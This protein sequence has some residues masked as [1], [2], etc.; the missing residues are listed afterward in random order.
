[1]AIAYGA[2]K[3][4]LAGFRFSEP[5]VT[6]GVGLV[7]GLVAY[8]FGSGMGIFG[9]TSDGASFLFLLTAL[10]FLR[11]L[12]V[13]PSRA[14]AYVVIGGLVV[15]SSS[16]MYASLSNPYRAVSVWE[17]T[18]RVSFSKGGELFLDAMTAQRIED[19][20]DALRQSGISNEDTVISL[21][22]RWNST[23][24]YLNGVKPFPTLMPTLFGYHGEIGKLEQNL[25]YSLNQGLS[26]DKPVYF[27]T[28][29]PGMIG[30]DE[31]HR[32]LRA[33]EVTEKMIFR[34][35]ERFSEILWTDDQLIVWKTSKVSAE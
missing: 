35:E 32:V 22:W 14:A 19:Y 10:I 16:S 26:S 3:L 20:G 31:R 34:D 27:V 33:K 13:T 17:Q 2:K 5:L 4:F 8:G 30:Q 6:I 1:M 24:P 11:F 21:L 29:G 15:T 23:L 25:R 9:K 18:E 12:N 28:D 7:G